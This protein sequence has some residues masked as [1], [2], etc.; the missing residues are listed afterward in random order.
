M[1]RVYEKI[2]FRILDRIPKVGDMFPVFKNT[3]YINFNYALRHRSNFKKTVF[4]NIQNLKL[5][6]LI[7]WLDFDLIW[8][9]HQNKIKNHGN[10]LMLLSAL[11]INL[12]A[13]G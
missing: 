13:K 1:R 4:N 5:R 10:A 11:E 7:D 6:K 3:N 12:R 9:E 2:R 8:R